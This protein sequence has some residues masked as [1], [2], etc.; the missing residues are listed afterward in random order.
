MFEKKEINKVT[1][2]V[3]GSQASDLEDTEKQANVTVNNIE[4]ISEELCLDSAYH[5][6]HADGK[7][8]FTFMSDYEVEDI[9]DS[10]QE[11]FPGITADLVSRVRVEWLSAD[12]FCTVV[13][14]PV[15][16]QT[17][18]W[19]AIDPVNTEVFRDIRIKKK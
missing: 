7:V 17:F 3:S 16:A 5:A 4:E 18:S 15:P 2:K 19:T 12:N 13:L 10:F 11:I 1:E 8:T 9:I 6:E 14:H